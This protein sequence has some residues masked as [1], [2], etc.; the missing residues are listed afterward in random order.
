MNKLQ[1]YLDEKKSELTDGVYNDL[2][3]LSLA[4][5]KKQD[6]DFYEI[7]YLT[8]NVTRMTANVYKNTIITKKQILNLSKEESDAIKK[9]LSLGPTVCNCNFSLQRVY[10]VLNE[11][12]NTHLFVEGIDDD[13]N[14]EIN[15]ICIINDKKIVALKLIE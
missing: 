1:E 7:M 15:D 5:Y 9:E 4:A 10:N 8:T 6:I 14:D 2:C 13:E 12:I 11:N 3:K